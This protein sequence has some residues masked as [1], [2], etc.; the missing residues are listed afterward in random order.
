MLKKGCQL[1]D[2]LRRKGH[3]ICQHDFTF[4]VF[5]F[6]Y[7]FFTKDVFFLVCSYAVMQ[8]CLN[9]LLDAVNTGCNIMIDS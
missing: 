9:Y 4:H 1:F 8:F 5:L 2:F 7:M 3:R 6:K